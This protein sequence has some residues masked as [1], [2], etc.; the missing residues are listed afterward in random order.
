[1]RTIIIERT[2]AGCRIGKSCGS[3]GFD[4]Q[5]AEYQITGVPSDVTDAQVLALVERTATGKPPYTLRYSELATPRVS[6]S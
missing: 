5:R 2:H 3:P 4:G 6:R 1:M